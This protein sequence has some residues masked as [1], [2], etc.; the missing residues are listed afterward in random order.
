MVLKKHKNLVVFLTSLLVVTSASAAPTIGGCSDRCCIGPVSAGQDVDAQ[1]LPEFSAS[2]QQC[3]SHLA[4]IAAEMFGPPAGFADSP[5][6]A[7]TDAKSLPA[8]PGALLM[9]VV[10]FICVSL[11]RDHGV[12]LTA[13]ASVLSSGQ[14]GLIALPQLASRVCSRV[15]IER[16]CPSNAGSTRGVRESCRLRS[17]VEGTQY[18]G[19]LRHLAGIPQGPV[20][21]LALSSVT[22]AAWLREHA[23]RTSKRYGLGES[24]VPEPSYCF[25]QAADCLTGNAEQHACFSPAFIFG[26]LARG[27]PSCTL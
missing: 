27:P 1:F 19:L 12:W 15:Q 9:V 25:M 2:A 16:D 3:D 5:A 7:S 10:G 26:N 8:V 4:G 17:H 23:I 13:M 24:A 11:A 21:L 6:S 20:S 14:A 18:V 22:R